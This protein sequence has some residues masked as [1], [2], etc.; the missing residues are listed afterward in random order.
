MTSSTFLLPKEA[1]GLSG[2]SGSSTAFVS[3]AELRPG[4][5]NFSVEVIVLESHERRPYI[6]RARKPGQ[7]S[8]RGGNDE[9]ILYV[10]HVADRSGSI[11]M[12]VFQHTGEFLNPGDILR[13]S[14]AYCRIYEETE[15]LQL[16]AGPFAP[17]RRVG[18]D[19]LVFRVVPNW[20]HFTWQ[21]DP[22]DPTS[23][24]GGI[25]AQDC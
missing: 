25:G 10:F 17:I 16:Y 20:S 9:V 13:I 11:V 23:L 6:K 18:E 24:V 15:S 2:S 4:R 3:I 12:N 7:N 5:Q 8:G 21:T 14:G 1:E 19:T 22:N